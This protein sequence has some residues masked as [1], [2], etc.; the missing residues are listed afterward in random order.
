[1]RCGDKD[2]M[3][4]RT[5]IGQERTGEESFKLGKTDAAAATRY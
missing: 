2:I 3:M 1:M 5:M 4:N